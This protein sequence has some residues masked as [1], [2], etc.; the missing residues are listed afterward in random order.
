MEQRKAVESARSVLNEFTI[1]TKE[2]NIHMIINK[3][4][5]ICLI[6]MSTNSMLV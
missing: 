1:I 6:L 4:I 3:A 5:S 2:K